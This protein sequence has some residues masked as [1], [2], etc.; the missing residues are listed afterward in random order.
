MPA[1][2]YPDLSS[3]VKAADAV[4]VGRIARVAKGREWVANEAI[5]G[6]PDV[7]D[8]A[9]ARFAAATISVEEVIGGTSYELG[10]ELTLELYLPRAE[11]LAALL[12]TVPT[13]RA[14]F[15]LRNKGPKDTIEAYR[16]VNDE[17]GLIRD[18]GG[19]GHL[20]AHDL[21]TGFT[22][23]EGKSFQ[24]IISVAREARG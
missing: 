24:S 15:V 12:E 9:Y 4:V 22:E 21:P 18:L 19:A 11:T 7:G 20:M 10:G 17:Q 2:D 16:L 13:E 3:A 5:I 23:L 6:D 8:R 1:E 14:L